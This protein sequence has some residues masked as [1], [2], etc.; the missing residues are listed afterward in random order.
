MSIKY[1]K[2]FPGRVANGKEEGFDA[3]QTLVQIPALLWSCYT[4]LGKL[5]LNP[6][7]REQHKGACLYAAV[8]IK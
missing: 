3:S 7:A 2:V 6:L 5:V 8:R 4:I 1:Y